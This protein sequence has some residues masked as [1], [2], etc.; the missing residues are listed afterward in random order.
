MITDKAYSQS[1]KTAVK[2]IGGA[3][4]MKCS[5]FNA[6]GA[7]VAWIKFDKEKPTQTSVL[8][9]GKKLIVRHPRFSLGVFFG[10]GSSSYTYKI[11][12]ISNT[13]VASYRCVVMCDVDDGSSTSADIELKVNQPP[14][15]LKLISSPATMIAREGQP[16]KLECY[17]DGFPEPKVTWSRQF[18]GILTTGGNFYRGNVL[19]FPNVTKDDRGSYFCDAVNSDGKGVRHIVDFRVAFS[20]VITVSN[21]IYTHRESSKHDMDVQCLVEAY[22]APKIDW[23]YNGVVLLND[24]YNRIEGNTTDHQF[25]FSSLSFLNKNNQHG[26]YTC[27]AQNTI[28]TAEVTA[29]ELP[30]KQPYCDA[31]RVHHRN[32]PNFYGLTP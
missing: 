18:N 2:D 9:I 3:I 19:S 30:C 29:I 25:S 17:A 14:V 8:S 26:K 21:I 4:D 11:K 24:N 1:I 6:S 31:R 28:G 32:I 12:N 7:P 20:P 5:V 13:D 16:S 27:K 22:P 23:L 10:V 15:I